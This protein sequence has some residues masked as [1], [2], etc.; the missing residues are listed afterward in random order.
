MA[1]SGRHPGTNTLKNK[2][3]LVVRNKTKQEVTNVIFPNGLTVGAEGRFFQNGVKIH[4]NTQ[5]SGIINSQGLRVNGTDI[6]TL[7]G[8]APFLF[9]DVD[10]NVFAFDSSSDTAASPTSIVLTAHQVS[11]SST[12]PGTIFQVSGSNGANLTASLG[13]DT[14]VETSTGNCIRTVTLTYNNSTMRSHFPLTAKIVHQGLTSTKKISKVEGGTDGA[15]GDDSSGL[16]VLIESSTITIA[17]D[18]NGA[19]DNDDLASSTK[20]TVRLLDNGTSLPLDTTSSPADSTFRPFAGDQKGSGFLPSTTG[21]HTIDGNL[22]ASINPLTS[23]TLT[24]SSYR[25]VQLRARISGSYKYLTG[26]QIINKTITSVSSPLVVLS[27]TA[28]QLDLDDWSTSL[29]TLPLSTAAL[30][31]TIKVFRTGSNVKYDATATA[32]DSYRVVGPSVL[33]GQLTNISAA[34]SV[35]SDG[36]IASSVT[37]NVYSTGQPKPSS[38][39]GAGAGASIEWNVNYKNTGGGIE[40]Y[41]VTQTITVNQAVPEVKKI[42]YLSGTIDF[43]GTLHSSMVNMQTAG[44]GF[45]DAYLI[46]STNNPDTNLPTTAGFEA[47][48][49]VQTGN[50]SSSDLVFSGSGARADTITPALVI[51]ISNSRTNPTDLQSNKA[52]IKTFGTDSTAKRIKSAKGMVKLDNLRTTGGSTL[53]CEFAID[54]F[55]MDTTVSAPDSSGN[56][57][58]NLR[59]VCSLTFPGYGSHSI[60]LKNNAGTTWYNPVDGINYSTYGSVATN[61]INSNESIVA[62]LWFNRSDSSSNVIP[63]NGVLTYGPIEIEYYDGI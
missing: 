32:H 6:L 54:L 43:G 55:A 14:I 25:T 26:Q 37:N 58:R 46:P 28:A 11:Q 34:P 24:G 22:S 12:I 8:G 62:V 49:Y 38:Y 47:G 3:M 45:V 5:V 10:S 15:A 48:Q 29:G 57:S 35:D 33:G 61:L 50:G 53:D 4:G 36:G 63:N 31:A 42:Q 23:C 59:Y 21:F 40:I 39:T 9:L 44:S 18:G 52:I 60:N 19:F 56:P 27:K 7:V 2:A 1:G 20:S 41:P 16:Q 30:S 51:G 17:T 13:S